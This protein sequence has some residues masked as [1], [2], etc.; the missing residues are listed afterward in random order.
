LTFKKGFSKKHP[1]CPSL[2]ITLPDSSSL[3]FLIGCSLAGL[4]EQTVT[5]T[6]ML[7]IAEKSIAA[8]SATRT[9][10]GMH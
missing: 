3:A 1:Q 7:K 9:M 5:R 2:K 4:P 10:S 8:Y 6:V